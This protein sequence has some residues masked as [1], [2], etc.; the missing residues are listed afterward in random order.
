MS[1]KKTQKFKNRGMNVNEYFIFMRDSRRSNETRSLDRK[2][3]NL[4][5]MNIPS[6]LMTSDI[7]FA[8]RI[9]DEDLEQE[10][11]SM[12]CLRLKSDKDTISEEEA[13]L[14]PKDIH[15]CRWDDCSTQFREMD[16]MVNHINTNHFK[17]PNTDH[18]CKWGNCPRYGTPQHSRFALLSH[19]RTHTA[20]KPFYCLL[21]ECLKA[22]TRADALLKH[23]KAVH[24]INGNSLQ[25]A[26]EN[27]NRE[28]IHEI[29]EF[30]REND[31]RVDF[32]S[33]GK[34]IAFDIEKRVRNELIQDHNKLINNFNKL[35]RQRD[36]SDDHDD[37][38]EEL[39][40]DHYKIKEIKFNPS[41]VIEGTQK[42][43]ES[44]MSYSNKK[45][46]AAKGGKVVNVEDIGDIDLMT[47]EQLEQ[48][49][50]KQTDYYARLVRLR[51]I[52]EQELVKYNSSARYY[53]LKKQYLLNHLLLKEE[54][55]MKKGS[56]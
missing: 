37:E 54:V 5:G 11:K 51:K 50:Q 20:E 19:I 38:V 21:P 46:N 7:V 29:H 56:K 40:A 52:L 47:V 15:I 14:D 28:L 44:L 33:S 13:K 53:W 8:R 23:L 24:N 43:K 39:I 49:I 12:D 41:M 55:A 18:S 36:I 32:E 6:E 45:E 22:F 30:Q 4:L 25:D 31:F 1:E 26:Y 34:K 10:F 17:Q 48:T 2:G 9:T 16:E 3:G 27:I 35:K 42:I